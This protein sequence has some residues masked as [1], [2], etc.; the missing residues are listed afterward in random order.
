MS[1][2]RQDLAEEL[3][4]VIR[5]EGIV[6]LAEGFGATDDLFLAGMDSMAVMQLLVAVE[7]R[8]GVAF[9]TEDVTKAHF[10]TAAALARLLDGKLAA[11]GNARLKPGGG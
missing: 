7:E 3:L 8:Y 2:D 10:G 11:A 5:S 6:G 1:G 4:G 9:A